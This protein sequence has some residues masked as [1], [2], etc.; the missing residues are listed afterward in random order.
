[1][2]R[3]AR[4]RCWTP[5]L[6]LQETLLRRGHRVLRHRTGRQPPRPH[7]VGQD[8]RQR[9]P[10]RG[11]P[12]ARPHRRIPRLRHH[13]PHHH[14]LPR[15]RT[16]PR[17]RPAHGPVTQA[18]SYRLAISVVSMLV[19]LPYQ[20]P[21]A[22]VTPF[23]PGDAAN[24]SLR[25]A[26][27][28]PVDLVPLTRLPGLR[29]PPVVGR[30]GDVQDPKITSFGSDSRYNRTARARSSS[31]YFFGAATNDSSPWPSDHDQNPP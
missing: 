18:S 21:A 19:T 23:D 16:V 5:E 12:L 27:S 3:R 28:A 17:V 14:R 30:L 22:A 15:P 25:S 6:A 1:V 7:P 10:R 26:G 29:H 31:G 11:R 13:G 24:S 9:T 8:P 2:S 4:T 20:A